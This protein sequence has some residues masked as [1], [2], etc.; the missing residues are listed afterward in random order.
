[1]L[2]LSPW[3]LMTA[4]SALDGDLK[5]GNVLT[6]VQG[7]TV[8]AMIVCLRVLDAGEFVRPPLAPPAVTVAA[9]EA[10]FLPSGAVF[11]GQARLNSFAGRI[12]KRL[13]AKGN[14]QAV[15]L[16]WLNWEATR[17][18]D[19]PYYLASLP[20]APDG[21]V[22]P[23]ATLQQPFRQ[24]YP[25]TCWKPGAGELADQI[26]VPLFKSQAGDWWVSFSLID[27]KTGQTLEVENPDGSRDHQV[28]L[29]PFR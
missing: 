3:L 16:L 28:G 24:L 18:M 8:I 10:E 13:D 14:E 21:E 5:L 20:V 4:A 7:V 11:G 22:P 1:M 23:A 25:T 27:G 15:L 26:E 12:E 17:A 29:G 19:V 9:S 2:F 6:L